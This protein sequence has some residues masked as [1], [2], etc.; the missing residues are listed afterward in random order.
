[1]S[2]PQVNVQVPAL[3]LRRP[4]AAAALAV[5]VETFDQHIRAQLP[6]IRLGTVVVYPVAAIQRFLDDNASS[7]ADE[8]LPLRH[9]RAA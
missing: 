3:A 5:S 7:M 2:R 9:R 6:T 1:M 4:E 8:L